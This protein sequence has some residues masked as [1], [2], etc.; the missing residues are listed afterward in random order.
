MSWMAM[1]YQKGHS[2]N[3]LNLDFRIVLFGY[4]KNGPTNK[5]CTS[6]NIMSSLRLKSWFKLRIFSSTL[7]YC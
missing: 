7:A 2:R 6:Q 5:H 3:N 4:E 1:E